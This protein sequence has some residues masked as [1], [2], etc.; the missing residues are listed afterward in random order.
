VY[1]IAYSVLESGLLS[2]AFSRRRLRTLPDSDWRRR[3]YQ[4]QQP[5]LGRTLA[6]LARLSPIADRAGATIAEVAITWALARPGV[7]GV[8]VGARNAEQ[9]QRSIDA[10]RLQLDASV[11]GEIETALVESDAGEGPVRPGGETQTSEGSLHDDI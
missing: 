5:R 8:I 6:L 11:L 7:G 10:A 3:R 2:G 4:F 9:V 1:T